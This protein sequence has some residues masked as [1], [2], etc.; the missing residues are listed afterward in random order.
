MQNYSDPVERIIADALT[1]RGI[2]FEYE[3]VRPNGRRI[4]FYLPAYDLFI[5]VKQF[6]TPRTAQQIEGMENVIV[7]QGKHAA[8]QFARLIA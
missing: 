8:Q 2:R 4:D 6:S 3:V 1:A 5:E 7:I